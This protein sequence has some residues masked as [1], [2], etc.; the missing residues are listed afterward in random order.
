MKKTMVLFMTAFILISFAA[1][2]N[3]E[4]A[5]YESTQ[6]QKTEQNLT[7]SSTE[8][9]TSTNMGSITEDK[10]STTMVEIEGSTYEIS[11]RDDLKEFDY[12]LPLAEDNENTRIATSFVENFYN[13]I[14]LCADDEKHWSDYIDI[15]KYYEDGYLKDFMISYLDENTTEKDTY[16][17][18]KY[19]Y[20]IA[21]VKAYDERKIGDITYITV[22]IHSSWIYSRTLND[23]QVYWS[24]SSKRDVI[25]IRDGKI[26][27][28]TI[29]GNDSFCVMAWKDADFS[30]FDFDAYDIRQDINPWDNEEYS[31]KIL[32]EFD[33]K[34]KKH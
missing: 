17:G 33:Y 2:R 34:V 15:D 20:E 25:G 32:Q 24:S 28:Q 7:V 27:N 5:P 3:N 11:L 12:N 1:C 30:T 6:N 31:V 29:C 26:V 4:K 22:I 16:R 18:R 9:V 21:G 14:D 19:K 10:P 13:A 8:A 23:D